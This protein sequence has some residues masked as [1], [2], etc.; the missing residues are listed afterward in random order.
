MLMF[1]NKRLSSSVTC[2]FI[3]LSFCPILCKNA[4]YSQLF[5]L[6]FCSRYYHDASMFENV[7]QITMPSVGLPSQINENIVKRKTKT[8]KIRLIKKKKKDQGKTKD[9]PYVSR[10]T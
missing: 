1:S 2:L 3:F 9:Y 4:Y 5:H 10:A 6:L 8:K 7:P